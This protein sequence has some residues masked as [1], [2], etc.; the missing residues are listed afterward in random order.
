MLNYLSIED[1]TFQVTI[2]QWL[3]RSSEVSMLIRYSSSAGAKDFEFFHLMEDLTKRLRELPSR[4]CVTVF[5]DLQLPLRGK[6]NDEF[7]NSARNQI[8]N[9]M[10]YLIVGLKK[11]VE[12]NASRFI[13]LAGESHDELVE[14]LKDY[15]GEEVA[16]GSYPSLLRDN[17]RIIS[18]I[19]PENDG[20]VITGIY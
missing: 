12:G 15:T 4:T 20:S 19:I 11:I 16:V 8:P 18:A 1:K 5:R 17:N 13:F 14:H 6:V 9:G 10:E 7:I 3:K 2:E